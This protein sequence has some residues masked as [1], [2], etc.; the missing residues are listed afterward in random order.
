MTTNVR[1]MSFI[2]LFIAL[3]VV[4]AYIKIPAIIG[5][6]A[7]DAF[8]ALLSAVFF[9]PVVGALVGFLGHLIS[10]VFGG[11]PLGPFHIIIAVEMAI[12]VYFFGAL[13]NRGMKIFSGI[14]YV[15]GNAFIAPIPFVF[16]IDF[17]FYVALLPSLLV[18]TLLNAI[19]AFM[20]IPRLYPIFHMAYFKEE[21][22]G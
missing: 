12:L 19:I 14:V 7:L 15:I 2:A 17:A 1:K 18:G 16:L 21:V 9:G 6:V 8:P 13:F 22:K 4:G 3:T 11:M 5:S 20:L 10:A